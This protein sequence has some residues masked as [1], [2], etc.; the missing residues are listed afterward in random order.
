MSQTVSSTSRC[1]GLARVS[2]AWSVSR[3]GPAH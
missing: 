1:Y 3:P 2:R